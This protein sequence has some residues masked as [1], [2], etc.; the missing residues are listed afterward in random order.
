[1]VKKFKDE[2]KMYACRRGK[3][4]DVVNSLVGRIAVTTVVT[5]ISATIEIEICW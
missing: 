4:E 1:M 5:V 2:G 3:G